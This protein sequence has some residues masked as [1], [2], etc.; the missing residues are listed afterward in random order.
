VRGFDGAS[1]IVGWLFS[2]NK[3]AVETDKQK[4]DK[5]GY[6]AFLTV[7]AMR[8]FLFVEGFRSTR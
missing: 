8:Q 3:M 4:A 5:I 6:P 2:F 1:P 7:F